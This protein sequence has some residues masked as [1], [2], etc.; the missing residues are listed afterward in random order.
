MPFSPQ[1]FEEHHERLRIIAY[2]R[3]HINYMQGFRDLSKRNQKMVN[4]EINTF[5]HTLPNDDYQIII[6]DLFNAICQDEIFD[7]NFHK[8]AA[9]ML[10]RKSTRDEIDQD[11]EATRQGIECYKTTMDEMNNIPKTGE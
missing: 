6:V 3:L 8:S 11:D 4:Q 7:E 9:N 2:N 10:I 1:D 5:I